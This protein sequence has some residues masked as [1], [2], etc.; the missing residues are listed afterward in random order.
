MNCIA[1]FIKKN[2][3][4]MSKEIPNKYANR[5][6]FFFSFPPKMK[7]GEEGGEMKK[8]KK[9]KNENPRSADVFAI[10]QEFIPIFVL[11]ETH[12]EKIKVF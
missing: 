6:W 7:N 12:G 2:V 9:K 10:C 11:K 4:R 1:K 8:K 3:S 5:I